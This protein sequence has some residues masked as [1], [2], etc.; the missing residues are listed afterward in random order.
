MLTPQFLK[1]EFQPI[2]SKITF[3]FKVKVSKKIN[4][5]VLHISL[6]M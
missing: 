4:L 2:T 1:V 5:R 3:Y 6:K